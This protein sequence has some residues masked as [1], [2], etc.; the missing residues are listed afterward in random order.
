MVFFGAGVLVGILSVGLDVSSDRKQ[1]PVL[2]VTASSLGASSLLH[3]FGWIPIAETLLVV[4]GEG[5]EWVGV[6]FGLL[7]DSIPPKP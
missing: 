4:R 6:R 3:G 2:S 5:C 1:T 7:G